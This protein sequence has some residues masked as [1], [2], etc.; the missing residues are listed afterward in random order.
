MPGMLTGVIPWFYFGLREA[1]IDWS[2]P[3]QWVALISIG[4]GIALLVACIIEFARRG[5]GTLSPVD[6]PRQLVVR[7]LYRYVRN[8]MYLAVTMILLGEALLLR[9]SDLVV[10][11]AGFFIA[12]NVFIIGYEEPYLRRHFGDSYAV[13]TRTVG[14]WIP[15]FPSNL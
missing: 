6:P 8:P 15:R 14:R 13:Y 3:L 2:D 7:G 1:T 11:W 5:R 9:S 4:L 12:A 10:Y